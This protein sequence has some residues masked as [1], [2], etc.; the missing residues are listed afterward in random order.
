M[1]EYMEKVVGVTG[2]GEE[3]TLEERSLL[4]VAYKNVID[5]R[6]ASWRIVSSVEQKEEGRRNHDHVAAFRG[7]RARIESKLDSIY[8]CIL[9]LLNARLILVVAAIN[10]KVFYL[11]TE[12]DYY[13]YMAEF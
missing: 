2:K 4:S 8:C 5:T 1:L 11:K 12:G 9:C 10:S 7:Y 13:C 6:C 3:L